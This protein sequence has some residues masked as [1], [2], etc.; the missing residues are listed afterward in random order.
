MTSPQRH[1][2]VITGT[3]AEF[4]LLRSTMHAI[5]SHQSLQLS[6]IVT[7]T[8]L[9][10]GMNSLADI[11]DD[12]TIAATVPMQ[13][14]NEIGRLADS[15]ALGRGIVGLSEAF[16]GINPDIVVVLGDRIEA[17]AAASAASVGGIRVAHIHGGDRAEG[18][19]D[20]AMRHAITKLAHI[21]FPATATSAA[22]II[23]MGEPEATVYIVGSPAVDGLHELPEL[24]D[25]T[26]AELGSPELV[27]LMHPIGR[28]DDEEA[29]D[30]AAILQACQPSGKTL[31]MHPNHDPGRS[32]ILQA[33]EASE[34][35][36]VSH[37]P[38]EKFIGL[39][40]RVGLLVGN[41]S[42]GLI[43]CAAIGVRCVNVG[44]RQRGRERAGNVIDVPRADLDKL[45]TVIREAKTRGL[46]AGEHR[47][48]AGDTGVCVAE[49]LATIDPE[50]HS[51]QKR[52]AY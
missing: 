32:G 47:Y 31:V 50:S 48:G 4:G 12:F 29:R 36:T 1:I 39:L 18:V 8:H 22:R 16:A 45:T 17:F 6:V 42:A 2:A 21:H 24:D 25:A 13:Q 15:R 7:G 37:L 30:M 35:P 11:E 27:V 9:L 44:S 49:L 52:N 23:A 41:S 51:L 20:E 26:F 34:L 14:D 28:A 19:A 10:P 38:R 40:K 5:A 33:I 46:W 3:R 43:E